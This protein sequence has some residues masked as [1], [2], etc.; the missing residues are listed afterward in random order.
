MLR[1]GLLLLGVIGLVLP[2]WA[3]DEDPPARVGRVARVDGEVTLTLPPDEA[4]GSESV[5]RPLNWPI[6][7]GSRLSTDEASRVEVGVGRVRWRLGSR[8]ELLVR[9]LDDESQR[10][11]LLRGSLALVL[12]EQDDAREVELLLPGGWVRPTG[13]GR[14]RLDVDPDDRPSVTA[15][16]S[17]V[18]VE[19]AGRRDKVR[20]GQRL[21]LDPSGAGHRDS[22]PFHDG[23]ARWA[24]N[25]APDDIPDYLP[26]GMTGAEDLT[27]A[28]RWEQSGE[29]GMVWHPTGV[30]ADWAPYQRGQWRWVPPWGWTWIDEQPWGFAP[31]H[32]GR[33]VVYR[34]RWVWAPGEASVMPVYAPAL[35]VWSDAPRPPRRHHHDRDD[36][37]LSGYRWTPLAPNEIYQPAYRASP[38]YQEDLNRPHLPRDAYRR[39]IVSPSNPPSP[40]PDR[41]DR[42]DRRERHEF[43]PA[44]A[45]VPQQGSSR[46]IVLPQ[47][48]QPA[49]MQPMPVQPQQRLQQPQPVAPVFQSPQVPQAGPQL[50]PQA[51]PPAPQPAPQPVRPA[52][53]PVAPAAIQAPA[54]SPA[55]PAVPA[56]PASPVAQPVPAVAPAPAP[57]KPPRKDERRQRHE[58]ERPAASR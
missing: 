15:F 30:S 52:P 53:R 58:E 6:T 9:E 1:R 36:A 38:R 2:V 26:A 12:P 20:P 17:S 56:V 25:E 39:I 43:R 7:R 10:L 22:E 23:F 31:F 29:W 48:Q 45:V 55:V 37:G 41:W 35:V 16:G 51:V 47:A 8:S 27:G 50:V 13:A 32:Y 34:G 5:R 4:Q 46:T 14:V 18:R 21:R 33:W 3:R 54:V 49:R 28:G 24:L 42:H 11:E 40:E 44:P 19:Y 57:V